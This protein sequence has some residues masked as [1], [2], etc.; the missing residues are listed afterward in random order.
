[1]N[2]TNG[3]A[4]RL[5]TRFIKSYKKNTLAVFFSF[6]LTFLLL[7]TMLVL[8]HT[9]HRLENIQLKTVLTPTD[10]YIS[11]LSKEQVNQLKNDKDMKHVAAA[12]EEHGI[13]ERRGKSLIVE[14]GDPDMITMMAKIIEGRLPRQEGEIAAEKWVLLNLGIEPVINQEFIIENPDTGKT[15]KLKLAGILS[16]MSGNKKYGI[17]SLYAPLDK[18]PQGPYIAYVQLK[19]N[20]HY[21]TKMKNLISELG[22]GKKQ[23]KKCPA[24]EDFKELYAAD[25]KVIAVILLICMVVFY[26]VYRIASIAREKQYGILRAVGMKKKQLQKMI[27]QELYT[28]YLVSVPVGIG[29]GIILSYFIMEVSGDRDLDI[30][31]FNEKVR[32][33]PIIPVWLLAGC[34]I[35]AALLIGAVGYSVGRKL[36]RRP[37]MEV[38][39]GILPKGKERSSLFGIQKSN[40]KA[41]TLFNM[42]CKY[43]FRDIK[44]SSFVILTVCLGITLF[45]G[46]GCQ[47]Q[48]ARLYR[49]DTKEMWYLNGEYAMTMQF[50]NSIKQGISRKSAKEI[51]KIED[52]DSVKTQSGLPIRVVYDEEIVQN[53]EYYD[54]LNAN[55][56]ELYG[57]ENAGNDGTNDVYKS[58]LYGYNTNALKELKKYVISGDFNPEDIGED[59]IILS[60]LSMDNTKTSEFP[61]HYK[62][63]TLLMDYKAGDEIQIKYRADLKTDT[64]A[65]ESFADKGE[66]IYKTFKIA[67][68]VS[69][70]YMYDCNRTVYPLLITSDSHIENIWP[71]S[72][73][74]CMYIDGKKGMSL[75]RQIELEQQLIRICNQHENVSARS[76]ISDIE[77]N[78]MF[79]HKQ[80]VY[81]YGIAVVAFILVLINI[82]NN[83]RYRMQTR[84]KEISMLRAIG[85]SVA[86]TRRMLLY[87]NLVLGAAG[88]AAAFILT[89]PVLRY[90]YH[91]SDMRAFAHPFQYDYVSFTLVTITALFICMLLSLQILKSWKTKHIVEGIENME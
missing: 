22:V 48:M 30:Y 36:V 53:H 90:L 81:I 39:S 46:L 61:G 13:Y 68:V 45:T 18:I 20:I 57:Y 49:E 6:A 37:V 24:K 82:I 78:E 91:I 9:N 33:V 41:R 25:I 14:K 72:G 38:I 62:D 32:V 63:G 50:F 19:E 34:V 83:L 85:M 42:G 65:Y 67:A 2:P 26:G 10:C 35:A 31:F 70:E 75:S 44:I 40:S 4:I 1:M 56:K 3:K 86:M 55:L 77:Q 88:A 84:T 51:E 27:F 17:I 52:V 87:E 69:F 16:D 80:M 7:T 73:F 23:I 29:I 59:E 28:I 15:E 79:Y 47:A 12:Q 89:Q 71:E 54:E 64:P 66:Y 60:V 74:Q 5:H 43:I 8:M 11:G 21:D 58:I 76:L